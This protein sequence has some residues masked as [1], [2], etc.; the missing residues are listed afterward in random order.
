MLGILLLPV[1]L[2]AAKALW[3]V[4]RASGDATTTWVPFCA[5]VAC[6]LVIFYFLPKPMWIY[7]FGHELTH[8]LWNWLFGGRLKKFKVS[9]R[10]GHVLVT[11]NNFLIA[12]APYFFPVY[13][14]IL[15]AMFAL[16]RWLWG[17]SQLL[18]WFHLFL[19]AAYGF[20]VT[21]TC[22]VL[23]SQ[24]SDITQH[25]Y[26]FSAVVIF[27]GNVTVLLIG[28]PLLAARVKL[29]TALSWWLAGTADVLDALAR[30]I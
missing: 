7:V 2:G 30:L 10:G 29:S 23:R 16:G 9:S 26:L 27:L 21:L 25:G 20:H 15:V 4:T 22:H 5:G 24:Q 6:W 13:A 18:P 1:C 8:A 19:G 12:L 17:W 3:L 28:I 14:V 11:K